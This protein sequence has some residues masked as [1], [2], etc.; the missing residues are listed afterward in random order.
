RILGAEI[1]KGE[2]E[3]RTSLRAAMKDAYGVFGVTDYW[4]HFHREP[5]HGRNLI[6]AVASAA[7][8]HFVFSSLHAVYERTNGALRVPHC[9]QK[10]ALEQYTRALGIPTTFVHVAFYYDNF[11]TFFPPR[12][13]ADGTYRFGFPQ[14]DTPL[15]GVA[16][17]D[18]GGVV[19]TIFE[20]PWR[21]GETVGIA[22]DDLAPA[23]Y[24]NV[25]SR[26]SGKPVRYDYIPREV[27]ASFPFPGADDLADMFEFNRTYIPSRQNDIEQ[28]RSL[29]PTMQTF[30]Q[31]AGSRR[32]AFARLLA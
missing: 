12:R 9:D 32:D 10:Y 7:V 17:E 4:E 21:I 28:S 24:A 13:R 26:V 30:E 19:A 2:L 6:N 5:E 20:Q 8:E 16:V 27:F 15:A 23:D 3:D 22:G 18:V 14:G 31:W 1:V 11:F 25:M 29:Y